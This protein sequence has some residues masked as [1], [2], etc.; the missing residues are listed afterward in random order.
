MLAIGS[1][2]ACQSSFVIAKD[3][4]GAEAPRLTQAWRSAVATRGTATADRGMDAPK[5]YREIKMRMDDIDANYARLTI[6]FDR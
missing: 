6:S 1:P 4:W 3:R 5:Y 2:P